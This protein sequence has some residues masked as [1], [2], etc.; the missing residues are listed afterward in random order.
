MQRWVCGLVVRVIVSREGPDYVEYVGLGDE[1]HKLAA[2]ADFVV[3]ALPLTAKTTDLFDKKFFDGLKP[4]TVFINVGRGRSVVTEDLVAA[5]K[6]GQLGGAGLDVTEPEP[7]PPAS[8]LWSMHNVI[9]TPHVSTVG[10]ENERHRV[11]VL[12][13]LR[14]YIAGD[15][16]LNV[17]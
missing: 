1:L 6:S 13:N 17:V 10:G 3:A 8:P 14:R 11:L 16:L 5:L 12:E 2:N 7:L 4:G 15:A 9:I